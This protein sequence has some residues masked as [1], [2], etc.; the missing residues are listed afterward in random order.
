VIAGAMI[1]AGAVATVALLVR[2]GHDDSALTADAGEISATATAPAA[3][4]NPDNSGDARSADNVTTAD[5]VGKA[6]ASA[7]EEPAAASSGSGNSSSPAPSAGAPGAPGAPGSPAPTATAIAQP[8][9]LPTPPAVPALPVVP[10]VPLALP[11]LP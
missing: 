11:A 4:L 1:L 10:T 7:I 9:A 5:G 6:P 8:P 2:S 3:I